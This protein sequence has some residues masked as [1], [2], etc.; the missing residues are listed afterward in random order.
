MDGAFCSE[1]DFRELLKT[2]GSQLPPCEEWD[3][4]KVGS[5]WLQCNFLRAHVD[6]MEFVSDRVR[7]LLQDIATD[8]AGIRTNRSAARRHGT[9]KIRIQ[10]L[11]SYTGSFS[12][13]TGRL[14]IR[15]DG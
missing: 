9:T 14:R 15:D 8:R 2:K 12:S 13:I 3:C 10:M 1:F 7:Q 5:A 11:S 6:A 4:R